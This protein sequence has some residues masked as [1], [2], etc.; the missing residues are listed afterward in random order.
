MWKR[1]A[2]HREAESLTNKEKKLLVVCD[3]YCQI[4][5]RCIQENKM[6]A[7]RLMN[8]FLHIWRST[9]LFVSLFTYSVHMWL[10]VNTPC[11]YKC[12]LCDCLNEKCWIKFTEEEN[13]LLSRHTLIIKG[14]FIRLLA[15][16]PSGAS[17]S[18]SLSTQS[19][20]LWQIKKPFLLWWNINDRCLCLDKAVNF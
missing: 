12:A 4:D 18:W 17:G 1:S 14:F 20:R 10:N 8:A 6:N 5:Q 3:W 11:R 16:R 13:N 7:Q 15:F 9:I 2:H 19:V